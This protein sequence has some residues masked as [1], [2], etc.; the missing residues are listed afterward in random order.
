MKT[1]TGKTITMDVAISDAG[2]TFKPAISDKEGIPSDHVLLFYIG[3]QV[4]DDR[5]LVGS[6]IRDHSALHL[7]MRDHSGQ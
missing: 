2:K 7:V 5:K 1:P 3:Q 6:N 4:K